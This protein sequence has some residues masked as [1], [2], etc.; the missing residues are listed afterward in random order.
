MT[1]GRFDGEDPNCSRRLEESRKVEKWKSR[2]VE[3][4]SGKWEVGK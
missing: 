1:A 4:K 2:E 3:V